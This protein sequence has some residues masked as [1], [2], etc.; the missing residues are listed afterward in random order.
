[1]RQNEG[2][3]REIKVPRGKFFWKQERA[4]GHRDQKRFG[5]LRREIPAWVLF[6]TERGG[7]LIVRM[8]QR[9]HKG[10]DENKEEPF[11]FV[12]HRFGK[13]VSR[14]GGFVM[15]SKSFGGGPGESSPAD[16][17]A[18]GQCIAHSFTQRA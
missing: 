9:L 4:R 10:R 12:G 15:G 1:V 3:S 13:S 6:S 2:K 5:G 8:T 7:V 11:F 18:G 16:S 17:R 14:I